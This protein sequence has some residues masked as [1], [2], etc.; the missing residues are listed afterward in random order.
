MAVMI[1]S[2]PLKPTDLL[3]SVPQD[4]WAE[5]VRLRKTFLK[6][7]LG[8]DCR[9]LVRFVEEAEQMYQSLGFARLV[10]DCKIVLMICFVGRFRCVSRSVEDAVAGQPLAAPPRLYRPS[11]CRRSYPPPS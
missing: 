6:T 8:Y 9:C 7:E 4:K 2:G 10:Q 1:D 3:S 5:L 11:S